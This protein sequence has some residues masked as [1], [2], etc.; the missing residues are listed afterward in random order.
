MVRER[1]A[2]N[3]FV[4]TSDLYA[5]VNAGVVVGP[6]WSAIID[7]LAYPSETRELKDFV[8]NRLG[9]AVRYVIQTHHHA[10]HTL[11]TCLFP[12]AVVIGHRECRRLLDSRGRQALAQAQ[13]A[14]RELRDLEIVL[15]DVVVDAGT[16][17]LRVGKRTL[18]LVPLP[19]HSPDGLGVLVEEDRVLFSGD[20]MMPL[21][22]L[23]DGDIESMAASLRRIPRMKLENLVQGHGEVI[24]RG[25]IQNAVRGNLNYLAALERHVR[26][27]SR[28]KDPGTFLEEAGVEEF[29]KSRILLNGLAVELHARNLRSLYRQTYP[30]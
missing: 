27:A 9:S 3:V 28:R 17:S 12:G 19:G 13:E 29:G 7:T 5:Q 18:E 10:D 30:R 21:P 8:E 26:R 11:G 20:V 15:P 14:N 6:E 24:L 25:E 16:V 22:Y 4:F 1:V 23:I 2:D